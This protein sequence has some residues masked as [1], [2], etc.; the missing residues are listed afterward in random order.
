MIFACVF[1]SLQSY[2]QSGGRGLRAYPDL[3]RVTVQDHGG[4]WWRQGSLNEDREWKLEYS[5]EMVQGLRVDRF[6]QKLER[7]PFRCPDCGRIWVA[8]KVCICGC[9]IA[10][11]KRARPVLCSDGSL[12][13]MEGAIFKPRRISKSPSGPNKWALMYLRSCYERGWRTFRQAEAL[14]ARENNWSWPDPSWPLMPTR[15]E[16]WYE[17]VHRVELDKLTLVPEWVR[18]KL[19]E[20][21]RKTTASNDILLT[22]SSPIRT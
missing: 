5:P 14:F 4:N 13:E 9:I 19:Q 1:H 15:V 12:R 22:N 10:G 11:S 7:E 8:R 6:R 18:D 3:E 17:M 20:I 2:L 16:D 21:R